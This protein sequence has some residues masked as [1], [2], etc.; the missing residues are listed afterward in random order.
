MSVECLPCAEQRGLTPRSSGAPTAWRTGPQA[1]GQRPILRFLSSTPRRRCP[2]SSNVRRHKQQFFDPHFEVGQKSKLR[3]SYLDSDNYALT[4]PH[5]TLG[6]TYAKRL[7]SA[8]C[9][10][11]AIAFFYILCLRQRT[12]CSRYS[13]ENATSSGCTRGQLPLAR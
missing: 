6:S 7:C 11:C 9:I 13:V 3:I 2:L 4:Y 12:D 10:L 5:T 8:T 1:R